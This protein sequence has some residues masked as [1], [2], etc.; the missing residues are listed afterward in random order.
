MS[1]KEMSLELVGT[2]V[3]RIPGSGSHVIIL[4]LGLVAVL[5]AAA[6]IFLTLPAESPNSLTGNSA[7]TNA[8]AA[9]WNAIGEHYRGQALAVERGAAASVARWT[10]MGERYSGQE[11]ALERGA[12]A[13]VA[14]W[15]AIGQRYGAKD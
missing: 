14:R 5:V 11:S 1:H 7:G 6:I 3:K 13:S 10:G 4:A 15:T 8:D 9:R 12:A 2:D